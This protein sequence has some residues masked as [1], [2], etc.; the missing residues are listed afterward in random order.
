MTYSASLKALSKMIFRVDV[1]MILWYMPSQSYLGSLK[2]ARF[3]P[4]TT[5][6]GRR[7]FG[8][9][10]SCTSWSSAGRDTTR[11]PRRRGSGFDASCVSCAFCSSCTICVTWTAAGCDTTEGF[12]RAAAATTSSFGAGMKPKAARPREG[13]A[14]ATLFF[15]SVRSGGMINLCVMTIGGRE[16]LV[17]DE[18]LCRQDA[19][20]GITWAS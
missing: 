5:G 16:G 6:L 19:R 14:F 15:F 7:G 20:A 2:E 17:G 18:I 8:F 1:P 3:T 10:A 12:T 4:L 9:G 13:A 11:G